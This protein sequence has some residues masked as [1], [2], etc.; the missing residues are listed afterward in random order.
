MR[1]VIALTIAFLALSV[2]VVLT[3][4]GYEAAAFLSGRGL[5]SDDIMWRIGLVPESYPLGE[6][7]RV[8]HWNDVTNGIDGVHV[9]IAGGG[10]GIFDNR[11]IIG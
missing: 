10:N 2:G 6:F 4:A 11:R 8:R 9:E 7:A 3:P 1:L 5:I